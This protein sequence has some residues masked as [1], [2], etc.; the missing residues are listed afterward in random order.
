MLRVPASPGQA[1]QLLPPAGCGTLDEPL[2]SLNSEFT[3][4]PTEEIRVDLSLAH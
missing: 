2:L 1:E 3:G 4:A